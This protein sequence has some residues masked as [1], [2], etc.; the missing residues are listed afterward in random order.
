LTAKRPAAHFERNDIT[1]ICET[2]HQSLPKSQEASFLVYE[3]LVP[4]Y[5]I[6]KSSP[7]PYQFALAGL[8]GFNRFIQP[9]LNDEKQGRPIG[10]EAHSIK[11]GNDHPVADLVLP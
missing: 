3:R 4:P 8:I 2:V 6:L 5:C 9:I 10:V 7:M 1:I 11:Q